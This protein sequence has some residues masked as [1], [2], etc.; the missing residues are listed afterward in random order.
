MERLEVTITV[1]SGD[2]LDVL[3]WHEGIDLG[4]DEWHYQ[5]TNDRW[6]AA[7]Q[8]AQGER[9]EELFRA[10]TPSLQWAVHE[11]ECEPPGR[12][13]QR[14]REVLDQM[15]VRCRPLTDSAIDDRVYV[16]CD[17]LLNTETNEHCEYDGRQNLAANGTWRCPAC[18]HLNYYSTETRS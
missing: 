8:D 13:V 10:M 11:A 15:E 1:E 18:K 14:I 7:Y 16:V 9:R 3:A 17:R 2:L 5:P 4:W 6:L 12:G